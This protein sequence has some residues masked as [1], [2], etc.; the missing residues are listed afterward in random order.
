MTTL[1][2]ISTG[3]QPLDKFVD[4][5][6]QIH[7]EIDYIHLRER[8]WTAKQYISAINQ[9]LEMGVPKTKIII[10]DR[11]DIAVT[12]DVGTVQLASHSIDVKEVKN[13]FPHLQIGSSVHCAKEAVERERDGA[14]YLVFGH[15]FETSS[16]P[17]L[18]SR[19]IK[20]LEEVVNQVTIPVIAIGGITPSNVHSLLPVGIGGIAVLSGVLLAEDSQ[21][22]V[23]KYRKALMGN[24]VN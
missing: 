1:H 8:S 9:M 3:R 5:I 10:N 15:V 22:A 11:V 17:G 21:A 20:Q 13:K 4:K 16:K 23:I 19:G 7:H 14:D 6:R 2:I 18:P 24:E 12:Q